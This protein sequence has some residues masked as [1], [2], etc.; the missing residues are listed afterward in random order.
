MLKGSFVDVDHF[1]FQHLFDHIFDFFLD[2]DG[3]PHRVDTDSGFRDRDLFFYF[4]FRLDKIHHLD[5]VYYALVVVL[6][7][8]VPALQSC[9]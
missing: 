3:W 9:E 7:Q 4:L 6:G 8:V 2:F 1:F 5:N